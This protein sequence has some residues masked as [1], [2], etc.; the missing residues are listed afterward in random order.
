VPKEK[1]S[2][3]KKLSDEIGYKK[4]NV[5]DGLSPAEN[6]A[7]FEFSQSY[8]HFL[9]QAKTEREAVNT[10]MDAA[11]QN[12]FADLNYGQN[13]SGK[14]CYNYRGKIA[15]LARMTGK[16]LK[17]GMKI[18][19]AHIDSPRL[20]I[21]QNPLYQEQDIVLLKTHYYGGIK[22]YQWLA[23]P[24][25]LHGVFV[26]KDG[27]IK[28]IT[29]GED[30]TDP[31]FAIED[32]L[33]HLDKKRRDKK[34]ADAFEGEK[35]NIIIGSKPLDEEELENRFK[36]AVLSYLNE[37]YGIIESDF[38]SAELEI[39]P[40]GKARDLG[41]D[42]SMVAAYGQDDRVCTYAAL[43]A[44]I[45]AES[46]EENIIAFFMDKEEI[47][48]SGNTGADSRF[49]EYFT[50]LLM[51]ALG[52]SGRPLEA[53][54]HSQCLSADVNGAID[55]D[56]P[57]VHEKMNAAKLGYGVC[58][59][60]F[61]G[62]GGKYHSS[63]A[64]AEFVGKIRRILDDNG[65]VWQTAELGKVDEGGGGT[66]ALFFASYGM[67]VIDCGTPVLSMHSPLE[68]SSKGDIY[69][70]YKAYKAFYQAGM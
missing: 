45:E 14:Y 53:L 29:L 32:L 8:K 3:Y 35:L 38:L 7:V 30:E 5:W 10:I 56:Y 61:T 22:K 57:D 18:V 49:L 68:I 41:F 65:V 21:K 20:D 17:S 6:E 50:G 51:D 13:D 19:A 64:S 16:P 33:P 52:Q 15:V 39:V 4:R 28:Q 36:L 48:S 24:L 66:I 69:N 62:S 63:D 44:V 40:A 42:R 37:K 67:D 2:K 58:I 12:G 43:R 11:A 60:K 59:T 9:D 70:T 23:R 27:S 55:P 1:E 26:L 34:L 47:G 46:P 31:V 25:A 54:A